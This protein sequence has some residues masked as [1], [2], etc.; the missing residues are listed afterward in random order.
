[1]SIMPVD[2]L[3][4]IISKDFI[5]INNPLRVAAYYGRNDLIRILYNDDAYDKNYRNIKFALNGAFLGK[6][7]ESIKYLSKLSKEFDPAVISSAIEHNDT[8]FLQWYYDNHTKKVA[9]A[10]NHPRFIDIPKSQA[11]SDLLADLREKSIVVMHNQ[12]F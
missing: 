4:L 8:E 6:Q 12:R 11:M 9:S 7:Y 2:L 3:E 5:F 10:L 1:M